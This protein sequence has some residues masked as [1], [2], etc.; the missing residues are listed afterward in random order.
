MIGTFVAVESAL[1]TPRAVFFDWTTRSFRVAGWYE[2][3]SVPFEDLRAVRLT[4]LRNHGVRGTGQ[5]ANYN[6]EI[7]VDTETSRGPRRVLLVETEAFRDPDTPRRM[8]LP[9]ATELAAALRL[10]P[11]LIA[12]S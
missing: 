7:Y 10:P 11:P 5:G 3:L 6:C 2:R 4:C 1:A 8:A 12:S 9:L